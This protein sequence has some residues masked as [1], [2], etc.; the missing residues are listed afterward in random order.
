M[1]TRSI[2]A[3]CCA[4]VLVLVCACD[5]DSSKSHE[6]NHGND[7]GPSHDAATRDDAGGGE[8]ASTFTPVLGDDPI[9]VT[10]AGG[11]LKGD[12]AGDSVRFLKIPYAKPPVGAL[13]W[14]APQTA[15]PWGGV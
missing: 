8:D 5:D 14:K 7:G 10:T 12:V 1:G 6:K 13:R 9:M 11:D 15:E 4:L 2:H 3:R